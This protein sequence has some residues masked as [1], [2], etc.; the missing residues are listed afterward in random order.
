MY[1]NLGRPCLYKGMN[2]TFRDVYKYV[3][4]C[5]KEAV[6]RHIRRRM[7]SV[8]SDINHTTVPEY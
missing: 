7:R 8:S 2:H 5:R 3:T 1:K 6:K 4:T